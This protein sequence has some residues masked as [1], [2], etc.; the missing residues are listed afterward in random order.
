M[1]LFAMT[2]ATFFRG[3]G[4]SLP[5]PWHTQAFCYGLGSGLSWSWH[6]FFCDESEVLPRL[7]QGARWKRSKTCHDDGKKPAAMS[8]RPFVCVHFS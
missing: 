8:K 6:V 5:R 4:K 1:I 3:H 7:R 2:M